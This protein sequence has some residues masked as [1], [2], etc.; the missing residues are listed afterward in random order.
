MSKYQ[1]ILEGLASKT[2]KAQKAKEERSAYLTRLCREVAEIDNDTF[3]G[4][5]EDLQEWIDDGVDAINSKLHVD[6]LPDYVEEEAAVDEGDDLDAPPQPEAAP[7]KAAPKKAAK[8]KAASRRN[9][10]KPAP[11][12]LCLLDPL[13]RQGSQ[14]KHIY[15]HIL[16]FPATATKKEII[17]AYDGPAEISMVKRLY[18][19]VRTII[20]MSADVGLITINTES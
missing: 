18:G 2:F 10:D 16:S 5:P 11:G 12:M 13:P 19:N 20:S 1:K 15:K 3:E 8:K 9:P 14:A 4:L 17:A 6:E 7:K